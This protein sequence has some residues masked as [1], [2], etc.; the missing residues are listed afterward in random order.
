MSR[1][2][3]DFDYSLLT[4]LNDWCDVAV[5]DLRSVSTQGNC[6]GG[7]RFLDEI[8]KIPNHPP[9]VVLC[10]TENRELLLEAVAR[11][12]Y[13]SVTGL[14]SMV[15][16]RLILRRA[17]NFG[18]SERE[19]ERLRTSA[20]GTGRLARIARNVASDAGAFHAG[21]ENCALRCERPDHRRN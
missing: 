8:D 17:H 18:S 21:A 13:D 2:S 10:D 12:A 9:A 11:G 5:L 6:E 3:K 4:D 16:L 1:C 7:L 20:R 19:L 14:P 15:E